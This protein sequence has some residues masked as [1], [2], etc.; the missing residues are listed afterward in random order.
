MKTDKKI[1]TSK[2]LLIVIIVFLVSLIAGFISVY[3]SNPDLKE[4]IDNNVVQIIGGTTDNDGTD[5]DGEDEEIPDIVYPDEEEKVF[6]ALNLDNGTEIVMYE[7]DSGSIFNQPATPIKQGWIFDTWSSTVAYTWGTPVTENMTITA[8]YTKLYDVTLNY[9]EEFWEDEARIERIEEYTII[10]NDVLLLPTLPTTEEYFVFDG[11]LEDGTTN[12]FTNQVQVQRDMLLKAKFR[13]TRPATVNPILSYEAE[14]K[15]ISILNA[16]DFTS[17]LLTVLSPDSSVCFSGN[18]NSFTFSNPLPSG[19]YISNATATDEWGRETTS[20]LN[21]NYV[22]IVEPEEP[23][24]VIQTI[25]SYKELEVSFHADPGGA[26]YYFKIYNSNYELVYTVMASDGW[27]HFPA[28]VINVHQELSW[29]NEFIV[30]NGVYYFKIVKIFNEETIDRTDFTQFTISNFN[31]FDDDA[32]S[33]LRYQFDGNQSRLI[34]TMKDTSLSGLNASIRIDI[35][36]QGST[37]HG[38]VVSSQF[39]NDYIMVTSSGPIT[40][41]TPGLYTAEITLVGCADY[42][43]GP[44]NY[45][46]SYQIKTFTI[47]FTVD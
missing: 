5:T 3:F 19:N 8:L 40:F 20:T 41:L 38:V 4:V 42:E 47:Q 46:K 22:A 28:M 36:K 44:R 31:Q 39:Y 18:V 11:W 33:S 25:N 16:S 29:Q 35:S 2:L 15:T 34:V 10:R 26:T 14:T 21:V 7:L 6:I 24:E 32:V 13:D 30:T 9:N 12:V 17:V 27:H 43:D 23:T 1:K 45:D 37:L